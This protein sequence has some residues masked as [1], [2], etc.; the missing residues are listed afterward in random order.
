MNSA[1][2]CPQPPTTPL[3]P[4]WDELSA[5]ETEERYNIN[6]AKRAYERARKFLGLSRA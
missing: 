3:L 4:L 1:T 6:R 5:G 2:T